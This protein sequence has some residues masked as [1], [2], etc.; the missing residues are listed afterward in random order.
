VAKGG[1]KFKES[2]PEA[3]KAPAAE[4]SSVPT[5]PPKL[6]IGKDG[7]PTIPKGAT[8]YSV[9]SGVARGQFVR[10]TMEKIA[11]FVSGQMGKPVADST[12]LKGEYDLSLEWA[13]EPMGNAAPPASGADGTVPPTSEPSGPNIFTALQE[14]LG[15]KLQPK[16][17]TIEILVIDHIEKTP[18]EN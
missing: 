13:P 12:G 7:F 11:S 1:P 14:Q 3:P 16:K 2:K 5:S 10:T 18:T 9:T 17:V 8:G 4:P 15:L 6:M